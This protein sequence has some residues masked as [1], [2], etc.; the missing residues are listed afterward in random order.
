MSMERT[1]W[2]ASLGASP[3]P[4]KKLHGNGPIRV[5]A[6]EAEPAVKAFNASSI[7]S[8]AAAAV[9]R[10]PSTSPSSLPPEVE[11]LC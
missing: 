4:F 2:H 1:L 10:P 3:S 5:G 7:E 6:L 8:A 11:E 9:G